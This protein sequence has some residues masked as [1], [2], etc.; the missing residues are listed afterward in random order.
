MPRSFSLD[1]IRLLQAQNSL[2]RNLKKGDFITVALPDVGQLEQILRSNGIE[3]ISVPTGFNA[4]LIT[5]T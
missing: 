5:I 4:Y 2:R 3:F 1:Q